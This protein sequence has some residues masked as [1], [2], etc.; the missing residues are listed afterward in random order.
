MGVT[1]SKVISTRIDN[2]FKSIRKYHDS[3]YG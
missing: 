3:F 2:E 1:D